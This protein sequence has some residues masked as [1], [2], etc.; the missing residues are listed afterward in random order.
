MLT[1]WAAWTAGVWLKPL[2]A[3]PAAT[4]K[5]LT[6]SAEILAET[7]LLQQEVE[8]VRSHFSELDQQDR[9]LAEQERVTRSALAELRR[10]RD[11]AGATTG[12]LE[13]LL[14]E[15]RRTAA[16]TA[17][18]GQA[19]ERTLAVSAATAD[20]MQSLVRAT[21]RVN[22]ASQGVDSGVNGLIGELERSAETF[23]VIGRLKSAVGAAA[24][25]TADWWRRLREWLPW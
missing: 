2:A 15:E 9:L 12:L 18:A 21:G 3:M 17:E 19:G 13:Q 6:T 16:L 11:L 20:Q 25:R 8:R 7:R 22:A 10:Q 1:A 23:E 5:V 14:A 24:E 4:G